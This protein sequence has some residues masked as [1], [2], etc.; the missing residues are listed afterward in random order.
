MAHQP[1]APPVPQAPSSPAFGARAQ[2][3]GLSPKSRSPVAWWNHWEPGRLL[4]LQQSSLSKGSAGMRPSLGTGS[5]AKRN[6][7]TVP[8]QLRGQE[9]VSPGIAAAEGR[10]GLWTIQ[11]NTAISILFGKETHCGCAVP[12]AATSRQQGA[13]TA[14]SRGTAHRLRPEVPPL[15]EVSWRRPKT[16]A[17]WAQSLVA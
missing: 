12:G 7:K 4:P 15:P 3:L 1:L 2:L 14:R 16:A 8:L 9:P 6:R 5:E 17:S 13:P 11:V 10:R